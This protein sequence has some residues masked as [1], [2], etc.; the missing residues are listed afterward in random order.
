MRRLI[1]AIRPLKPNRIFFACDGP[2][3]NNQTQKELVDITR[4]QI[5]FIDW[6]CDL[7]TRFSDINYGCCRGM[8]NAINWFFENVDAGII[9]EDDCIPHE[10]FIPFCS[11]LL[12]KYKFDKR[13][14]SISGTNFQAGKFRGNASYYLSRYFQCWGWAT[15]KRAWQEY[16]ISMGSW[17]DLKK[18]DMINS[19]FDTNYELKYWR[20][21]WDKLYFENKPDSWAYRFSCISL[22][23]GGLSIIPNVNLVKNIGFDVDATNT[24]YSV[25]DTSNIQGIL[26]LSHPKNIIRHK[27]ADQY[28]FNTRFALLSPKKLIIVS[29][30]KPFY[31]LK[32][33]MRLIYN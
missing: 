23:N 32:K 21:V 26:P 30:N 18:S 17:N 15:W 6:D 31:Y 1:D 12:E 4:E 2:T 9:L 24:R 19:I 28:T 10:E 16:D 25:E 27:E 7:S 22:I 20:K 3:K 13:I 14:W 29:L 33:I 8:S 5:K 11:D